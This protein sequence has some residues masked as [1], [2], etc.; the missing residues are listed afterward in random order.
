VQR[1]N[2]IPFIVPERMIQ[3]KKD[4]LISFNNDEYLKVKH[5]PERLPAIRFHS[6]VAS[7]ESVIY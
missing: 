7:P 1:L 6:P 3:I 5:F 2:G 4:T